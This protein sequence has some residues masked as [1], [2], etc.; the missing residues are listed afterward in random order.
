[1]TGELRVLSFNIWRNGGRSLEKTI[2]AIVA[3]RADVMGLQECNRGTARAIAD[4]LAFDVVDDDR[5]NAILSRFPIARVFGPTLDAWGGLG[6]SIELAPSKRVHLFDAHLHYTRY[7]P[8]HLQDGRS[9]SFV[10]AEEHAVR[11]PGL[12]ELLA[13]MNGPLDS[14]EPTFLV[15]DFNAPSHLDYRTIAW[16]VSLACSARGLF[17]S[18]RVLHP[19]H[20][21]YALG[22]PPFGAD[23]PGITWTAVASEEPRGTFD[24]IDF[25]HYAAANGATPT[26]S[27]VLDG[28]N[29]VAPWPS[30][31]RAV[32]STFELGSLRP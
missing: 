13:L 26:A 30:D 8:H 15:G 14:G 21:T 27:D 5:G 19:D 16:P 6:A 32:A 20:R 1:V 24:R 31:H 3:S 28:R 17:D 29:C 23:E 10:V 25:V 7:G 4:E 18:Y 2:A 12:S 11:M 9:A 22:G